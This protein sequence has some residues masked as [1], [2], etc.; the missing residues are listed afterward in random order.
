MKSLVLMT[1]LAA[2]AGCDL[3]Y[4]PDVGAITVD[5]FPEDNTGPT[6]SARCGDSDPATV[7]SFS[8]DIQ[9]LLNRTSGNCNGCH[10]ALATS[11]FSTLTHTSMRAGGQVG[12]ART[13][14]P[15][16]PCESTLYLK[17]GVAP[18]YGARMPYTGPPYFSA[19]DLAIVRDWIAEGALDN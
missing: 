5:A 8:K 14:V 2:L 4:E 13:V 17:L 12:G 3:T 6:A 19:A 18:P 10:G 7:V 16:K 11:G 9:P 15:G 1:S